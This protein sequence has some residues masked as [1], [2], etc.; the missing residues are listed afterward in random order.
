[1]KF[2][3]FSI[4]LCLAV[5]VSTTST[6]RAGSPDR[7][8]R[9]GKNGRSIDRRR[10]RCQGQ[11]ETAPAVDDLAFLRAISLDLTGRIPT[12]SELTKYL[13][14]P[15]AERRTRAIDD[16]MGREQFADRWAIFFGDLLRVR[17]N[18]DGGAAFQAF[19]HEAVRVNMPYDVMTRRLLGAAGRATTRPETGFILGDDADPYAMTGVVSQVFMGVRI[20]CAQCHDHPFDTWTAR[21]I[22]QPCGVFRG[23]PSAVEHRIKMQILGVFLNERTETTIMWPPEDKAKGKRVAMQ[24]VVPVQTRCCRRS[25]T[26]IWP[27]SRN[28]AIVSPPRPKQG[29]PRSA[30]A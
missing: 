9:S 18:T 14:W 13:S 16:Y 17:Y 29:L 5:A 20:S 15:V 28:C 27:D 3:L 25:R 4:S 12:E 24:G 2:R 21:R 8:R 11:D 7:I 26:S 6:V 19:V 1:M 22:L 23:R 30:P 10:K